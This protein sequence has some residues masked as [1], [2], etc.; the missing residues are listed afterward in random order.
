M[1]DLLTIGEEIRISFGL[2]HIK[3]PPSFQLTCYPLADSSPTF[4]SNPLNAKVIYKFN[5]DETFVSFPYLM[6]QKIIGTS[7]YSTMDT[8]T[9][10]KYAIKKNRNAF[11]NIGDAKRILREI[12]LMYHFRG[13][14]NLMSVV[15]VIAQQKFN[16][17]L[18]MSKMHMPLRKLIMK[19]SIGK[20]KNDGNNV[21]NMLWIRTYA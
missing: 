4:K 16:V 5:S 12:K 13:D 18:I 3:N 11:V 2:Q 7:T 1:E 19:S 15:D 14:S 21:S 20:I 6:P 9:K 8:R 10:T 17:H